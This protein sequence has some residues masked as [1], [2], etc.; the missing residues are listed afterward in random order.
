MTMPTVN[1]GRQVYA[2]V[3]EL[4]KLWAAFDDA[5]ARSLFRLAYFT[6]PRWRAELLPRKPTDIER[7]GNEI[8]LNLGETKNG[9]PRMKWV[10][11]D[12]HKDLEAL[13]FTRRD[14]AFYEA[15]RRAR[16]AIGRPDLNPHDLRHSLASNIVSRG[17]SLQDVQAALHHDSVISSKRYAHLYPER[18]R[19]VLK[20][21]HKQPKK[22]RTETV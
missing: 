13:P 20:N 15:F 8:W 9:T 12:A 4:D 19:E 3:D 21:A 16:E 7:N 2:K 14:R 22:K 5:E 17:G 6:G 18:L 10:H 11:P 1:N